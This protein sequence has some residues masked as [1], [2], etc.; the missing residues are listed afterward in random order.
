MVNMQLRMGEEVIDE[1]YVPTDRLLKAMAEKVPIST[2][3]P[4]PE[5]LFW[6]Y[7]GAWANGAEAIVSLHL[8]SQLSP[9]TQAAL[10]AATHIR[11]PVHIV[12]SQSSGMS[13]GFAALSAAQAAAGGATPAQ[14]YAAAQKRA[15]A[16]RVLIYVDTLEYLHRAGHIGSAAKFVGSRLH[17]KPLLTVNGGQVEPIGKVVGS[18]RAVNKLV[19]QA[20][21][22]AGDQPIDVAVEHFAAP[23]EAAELLGRLREKLPRGRGFVLSQV[24]AAIGSNVGPGAL[25]ITI[26]PV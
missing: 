15:N 3:A 21:E 25:A 19:E 13:L 20:V 10:G 5:A 6:T 26:C 14:V 2:Q 7:Q 22:L 12:D 9:A 16:A 18:E 4:V 24:S 8:S 17:V 1:S 11:I 23:N